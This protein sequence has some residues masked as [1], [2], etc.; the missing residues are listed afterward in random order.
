MAGT[1]KRVRKAETPSA[2]T[3]R[4]TPLSA[5]VEKGAKSKPQLRIQPDRTVI[6]LRA[7]EIWQREG[8]PEGRDLDHW[9]R[10]ERELMN[11]T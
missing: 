6:A 4:S 7:W 8:C 10:A 2:E 5:V 9:L 1:G 3:A 11:E